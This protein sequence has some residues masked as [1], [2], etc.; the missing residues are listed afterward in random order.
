[1]MNRVNMILK[2][3]VGAVVRIPNVTYLSSEIILDTLHE[4]DVFGWSCLIQDR[5]WSTLRVIDPT[6][7][8]TVDG[9]ALLNLFEENPRIGYI[10]MRHLAGLIASRLRRN[11]M[12]ML[13][14]IVAIR[15]T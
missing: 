12:S 10:V 7:V 13:N 11:R 5:P 15:G 8:L 9:S 4:G 2:G 14:A 3:R 1:S 6:E